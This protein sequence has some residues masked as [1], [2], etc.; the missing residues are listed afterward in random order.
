MQVVDVAELRA[1][2]LGVGDGACAIDVAC[3]GLNLALYGVVVFIEQAQGFRGTALDGF[4]DGLG[5]LFGL[6]PLP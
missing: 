4:D 6:Y 1:C 5:Q 2:L 3:Y